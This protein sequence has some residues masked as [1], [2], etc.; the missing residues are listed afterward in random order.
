L[1]VADERRR[2]L[3]L[4]IR[5]NAAARPK[6]S[7]PPATD[8][9]PASHGQ[10]RLWFLEQLQQ[11][12]T[13]Y[14]LHAIQQLPFAVEPRVL[15]Q[16]LREIVDR[17]EVLRTTIE[18]GS[19]GLLQRISP[20]P[21][22]ALSVF[23]LSMLPVGRAREEAIRKMSACFAERFDLSQGPL[24]R[25][26]LH[27]LPGNESLLLVVVHHIVFDGPSFQIFFRELSAIY[28]AQMAGRPHGLPPL[29]TQYAAFAKD[30]AARLTAE[31]I[32]KEVA[33]WRQE[34]E[35]VP[36]LDLPFDRPRSPTPSFR[37]AIREV[38]IGRDLAQRLQ[39]RASELKATIFTV[40]LAS[41]WAALARI[42][43]QNDFAL[44]LPVTGRD[45]P[46]R[47][48]AIGFYVDTVVVRPREEPDPTAEQAVIAAREALTR[49]IA[50][51]GLPFEMLVLHLAPKRDLGVNPFFQV[52]FQWMEF[53]TPAEADGQGLARS[54]AMFDLGLDLWPLG[55][56]LGGRL[57]YNIDLFDPP[58]A[59][60]IVHAFEAALDWITGPS[61][62]LRDLDL[63]Q[64]LS[65]AQLSILSGPEVH[66]HAVT[67]M[68]L[69]R[70]VAARQGE[71]IALEYEGRAVSYRELIVR[72][73]HLA[74][75]LVQAGVTPGAVVVLEMDRLLDLLEMQLATCWAGAA[76][77]CVD[78]CW[79]KARREAIALELGQPL[80]INTQLASKLQK[81]AERP[82]PPAPIAGQTAYVIFTSGST[83]QPKG[84][85]LAHAG[86][87]NVALSQRM[88]FA[89]GPGRRV[90]KLASPTFDASIFETTL[91]LCSG[92]T[93]VIARPGI[94]AG[95]E[96][97]AFLDAKAVDTVVLPPSVLATLPP[98][99]GNSL[100]LV[101][102]AGEG[103]PTALA[104]RFGRTAAFWNLYGPTEMTIWATS[105]HTPIGSRVAI[106]VPIANTTTFVM[107]AHGRPVP[108]GM[109][110]EL[111][112][113]GPGVAQGYL[114]RSEL[115]AERFVTLPSGKRAYRTGDLVRQTRTGQLVFLGRT[116]RQ[117]KVRGLRIELDEVEA[118]LR[119]TPG[120]SEVVVEART[121][122]GLPTLAAYVLSDST[123]RDTLIDACRAQLGARLPK[124]MCPS[125]FVIVESLPRTQSGKIDRNALPALE[126]AT[127]TAQA[128]LAPRSGTEAQVAELMA[129]VLRASRVGAE[130][131]FFHIGGH[132]L[133]A[134]RLAA[135][136]RSAMGVQVTV[137]E[138]FAH[139]TVAALARHID[140]L[141]SAPAPV[142]E[143]VELRRLPRGRKLH[144]LEEERG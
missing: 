36:L 2:L 123:A 31:R 81:E 34:L 3:E 12:E 130:D 93:L 94:L 60:L 11:S 143:E 52:G 19:A 1:T 56:G 115:T 58:T 120:V 136:L 21:R 13:P 7:E 46:E 64:G 121:V 17:H 69:M 55:E 124:S 38:R 89:L 101:C 97:E 6:A 116:D 71:A 114:G 80:R 45:T 85:A 105:G 125:H 65:A 122:A 43:G 131:D 40:L 47:Q 5:G 57:E 128:Y 61:R 142:G 100:K 27:R 23:D 18:I 77:T 103:C 129:H 119:E 86:L 88:L 20:E 104:E 53:F 51:R 132:S 67:W 16:S 48:D 74:G 59:D 72:V 76:F 29:R 138:V 137:A 107:D 37:G 141:R 133:A 139:S 75:S 62:N 10:S 39:R 33:F 140:S 78:P 41:F 73:Q 49:S 90:A 96:L 32:E 117:V 127:T 70:E 66:A 24:L 42:C 109:L 79:P 110:G 8:L 118:V 35:S 68:D 135:R 91:A 87:T 92:A 54:S 113:T 83:G 63:T 106:G 102:A 126:G 82:I 144:D 14:N 98:S 112:V 28:G 134:V 9:A 99:A 44:G 22:V 26:E 108:V 84:V 15:E 25:V 111:W 4:R 30:Q 50:H 95:G